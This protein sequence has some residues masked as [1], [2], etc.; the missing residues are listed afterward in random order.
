MNSTTGKAGITNIKAANILW[1][2]LLVAIFAV[3][4]VLADEGIVQ[5]TNLCRKG[6]IV[7]KTNGNEYVAAVREVPCLSS[8]LTVW[9]RN[10]ECQPW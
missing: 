3:G 10:S 2:T 4:P 8:W 9:C 7:I 6:T 1:G 5:R